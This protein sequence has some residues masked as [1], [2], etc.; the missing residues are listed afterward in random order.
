MSEDTETGWIAHSWCL[1]A[2][3]LMVVQEVVVNG[4]SCALSLFLSL[5]IYLDSVCSESYLDHHTLKKNLVL[6]KAQVS[7]FTEAEWDWDSSKMSSPF[8]NKNQKR[9]ESTLSRID[10]DLQENIHHKKVTYMSPLKR[11]FLLR[12]Q[13]VA[14][15]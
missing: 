10:I 8:T 14:S 1:C 3:S 2:V 5:P 11:E 6:P 12:G 13:A 15:E 4:V 7:S 9:G